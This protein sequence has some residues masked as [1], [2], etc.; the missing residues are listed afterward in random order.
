MQDDNLH[1]PKL[2]VQD[3]MTQVVHKVTPDMKVYQAIEMLT[4][5]L[6][7]GAP[8]VDQNDKLISALSEGDLMRLAATDGLEATIA[9]CLPKLPPTNKLIILEKHQSFAE[10]YKLFLKHSLHRIV[11]IDGTGKITGIVTRADILRLFVESRH[12]KKL[13][14][15]KP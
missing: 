12:G 15:R 9:H 4:R 5:Y 6:I 11:V 14:P 3:V 10:A 13:P 7:S 2:T 8:V 1:P